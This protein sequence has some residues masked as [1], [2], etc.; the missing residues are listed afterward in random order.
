MNTFRIH[1][2]LLVENV[3]GVLG[4]V[5]YGFVELELGLVV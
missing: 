2:A 5:V 1:Y 3:R 4:V